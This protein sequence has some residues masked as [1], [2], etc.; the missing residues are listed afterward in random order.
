MIGLRVS[1][2]W[3]AGGGVREGQVIGATDDIG[4]RAG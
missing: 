1:S 3:M 2:G 4:F